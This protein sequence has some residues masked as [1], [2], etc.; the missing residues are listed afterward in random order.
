M[1]MAIYSKKSISIF[2]FK[3]KKEE[4]GKFA[5]DEIW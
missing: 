3:T 2:P 5:I 1:K 4:I